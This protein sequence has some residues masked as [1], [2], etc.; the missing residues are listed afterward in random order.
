MTEASSDATRSSAAVEAFL[1]EVEQGPCALV[2]SGEPGIGKTI[3]WEGGLEDGTACATACDLPR[4]RGGGLAL[5]RRALGAPGAMCSTRSRPRCCRRDGGRSRSRSCSPSPAR[6]RRIRTPIGLAVLDVLRA[7]AERGPVFVA[8]D[9]VQWLDPPPPGRP[10]RAAPPAR[11][12]ASACLRRCG[13]DRSSASP[14]ELERSFPERATRTAC[15]RPAQRWRRS[16]GCSRS[17][18]GSS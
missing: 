18:S 2:L 7:L 13:R 4:S 5:L 3:L 6:R 14:F 16:T 17:G 11:R 8:L 9:D 12:A 15:A 10:D 1:A